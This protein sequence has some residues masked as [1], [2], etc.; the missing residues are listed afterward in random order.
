MLQLHFGLEQQNNGVIGFD[1]ASDS[2]GDSV[3]L[4][5][6]EKGER[7]ASMA[8]LIH[9]MADCFLSN[10]AFKAALVEAE[11]VELEPHAFT[12]LIL[13]C[14]WAMKIA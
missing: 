4:V 5:W 2:F 11:D 3:G 6:L 12:C 9:K 14:D 10:A 1:S 7:S 8:S 13:V